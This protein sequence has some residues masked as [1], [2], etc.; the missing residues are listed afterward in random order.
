MITGL[1]AACAGVI[2]TSR[3]ATGSATLGNGFE[4]DA[5]T[6]VILGGT[7]LSGGKGNVWGTLIGAIILTFVRSG[8]NMLGVGEAYQ[9]LAIA[10]ILLFALAISGIKLITQKE[11]K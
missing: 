10:I 9:K 11:G 6:A 4:L 5:I 7:S 8:L 3:L 1:T 2:Q